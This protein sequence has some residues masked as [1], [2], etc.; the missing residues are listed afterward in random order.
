M[1]DKIVILICV[2]KDGNKFSQHLL[3]FIIEDAL[4]HE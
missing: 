4:Y 1:I 3:D 2:I